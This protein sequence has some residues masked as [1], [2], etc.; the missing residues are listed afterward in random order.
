MGSGV[1]SAA[2]RDGMLQRL[3]RLR[4]NDTD[5]RTEIVAGL[6]TFMTMAYIIFVNPGIVSETGMP[7]DAVLI[8]TVVAA[9]VGTLLMALLANYPFALAPGMGLNAYF[10]FTIVLGRGIPWETA[11]GA[12]FISGVL[13]VLLTLSRVREAIVDAVP[14]VLKVAISGGIGLFIAFIGVQNSGLVVADGATLVALGDLSSPGPLLALIGTLITGGLL[15][16]QVRG[17]ILWGIVSVTGLGI[18]F[19]LV[20]LPTAIV[21]LPKLSTWAPVLGKLNVVDALKLGFFE[22]VLVFLFVDLFDTLGTLIG[23]STRANMLDEHGRLPRVRPALLADA[24]GTM[25]GAVAGT[26]TVTT[27][28]ESASGVAAGGRTGLTGVTVAAAFLLSLFFAP[29][30]RLVAD[31]PAATAPALIIVGALMMQS[32]VR[33]DWEDASEAIPAFMTIIAMPFTYS[34]ATGIGF[35]FISYPIV[36]LIAGKGRDVHWIVYV[37]AILFALRFVFLSV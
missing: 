19:G 2:S 34:I 27:Y 5:V 12:V 30:V 32:V 16:L 8:G 4:E 36:K 3:F 22:I 13:F 21:E 15:A 18:L 25:F 6:T 11:L 14:D 26:P 29:V 17:A 23:V 1:Q 7:F 24:I 37:L 20:P 9:A 35:G 28:V 31:M 10:A 33:I